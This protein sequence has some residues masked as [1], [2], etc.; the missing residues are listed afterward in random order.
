[1]L[2]GKIFDLNDKLFIIKLHF[3]VGIYIIYGCC[4]LIVTGRNVLEYSAIQPLYMCDKSV[5]KVHM[6][7]HTVSVNNT[8]AVYITRDLDIM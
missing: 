3:V 8:L 5:H 2:S 4:K 7:N 1:M 6:Y